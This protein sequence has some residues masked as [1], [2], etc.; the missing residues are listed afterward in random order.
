MELDAPKQQFILFIVQHYDACRVFLLPRNMACRI[1]KRNIKDNIVFTDNSTFERLKED[2]KIVRIITNEKTEFICF[3]HIIKKLPLIS[4]CINMG[5]SDEPILLQYVSDFQLY[6]YL[7]ILFNKKYIKNITYDNILALYSGLDFLGADVYIRKMW[8]NYINKYSIEFSL[9]D[10]YRCRI[11]GCIE[12]NGKT[13]QVFCRKRKKLFMINIKNTSDI[14]TIFE[15][16][17]ECI[18]SA[19]II[20]DQT[21][22]IIYQTKYKIFSYNPYT[23]SSKSKNV[24]VYNIL[25]SGR[26]NNFIILKNQKSKLGFKYA[27]LT[28]PN[29]KI[30]QKYNNI[31]Q[32]IIDLQKFGYYYNNKLY[33]F[34]YSYINTNKSQIYITINNNTK[35]GININYKTSFDY[36][37]IIYFKSLVCLYN[38]YNA[39]IIDLND[40][41]LCVKYILNFNLPH[42]NIS[43][44][45]RFSDCG[46]YIL[47]ICSDRSIRIINIH[48]NKIKI[49]RHIELN[50]IRFHNINIK[51]NNNQLLIWSN[52]ISE[53]NFSYSLMC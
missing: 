30:V 1:L 7:L 50:L 31:T 35:I 6:N 53:R 17:Q 46:N 24:F 22:Y 32:D 21:Y 10:I 41:I 29:L 16:Q 8:N 20:K 26:I 14:I 48:T 49:I 37:Y 3:E 38:K 9:E 39:I 45:S 47:L 2:K 34:Q 11:L 43:Q 23:N 28:L 44:F 4:N 18:I 15:T 5:T 19:R 13:Y 27:I 42:I 52:T 36:N 33:F 12:F 51:L 25:W 40:E